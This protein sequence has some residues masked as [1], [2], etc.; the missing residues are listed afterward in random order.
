MGH[1]TDLPNFEQLV[2][3]GGG[4]RCFWHGGFCSVVAQVID[5][6]PA[7]IAAVSGGALSASAFIGGVENRLFEVMGGALQEREQNISTDWDELQSNGMTPHQQMYRE[8]VT[9]TLCQCA[10]DAIAQGPS[11]QVLLTHPPI[12]SYPKLSTLPMMI[13]YEID[14]AVRSSPYIVS[15]NSL[16]AEQVLVDARQAA[17]DGELIDLVCAAAVIPPVFNVQ[18]WK[19]RPVVDG[20]MTTSAPMPDPDEGSTLI[21]LTRKFRHLPDDPGHQYVE[22]SESVPADKIDFTSREKIKKTWEA[23][24][25][26]GRAFL[27]RHLLDAEGQV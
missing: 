10:I 23:G 9:E 17:R 15:A 2:F 6:K 19:G 8:I 21:L 25:E 26:D 14:K 3:S 27:R 12:E 7:R 1:D 4:T 20:G 22:P 5:L 13:S 18:G 11:F 16:G 24:R